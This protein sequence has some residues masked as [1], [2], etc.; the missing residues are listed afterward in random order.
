[1]PEASFSR[2][3]P[4]KLSRLMAAASVAA[5]RAAGTQTT[6]SS[7]ATITSP[8][9]TSMPAH[10]MGMFTEPSVALIVP[11]LEMALLHTGKP[12]FCSSFTSRTP[13]SMTSARA[14]RA[15]NEVASKSPK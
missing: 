4:S 1:M 9:V 15:W 2:F 13:A 14:P 11:L 5:A 10:T 12:I 3:S 8:G 6:P 7:S